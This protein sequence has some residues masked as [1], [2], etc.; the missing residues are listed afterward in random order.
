MSNE[1]VMIAQ[2]K[3]DLTK[4]AVNSFNYMADMGML[5]DAEASDAA[6]FLAA[7]NAVESVLGQA[8]AVY[9]F[10]IKSNPTYYKVA[11]A[12]TAKVVK[13]FNDIDWTE[14]E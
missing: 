2:V 11:K 1:S 8:E 13:L 6:I 9:G 4:L 7:E 10:R 5:P 14:E 12:V 3:I